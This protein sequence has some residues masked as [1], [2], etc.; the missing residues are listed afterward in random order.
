MLTKKFFIGLFSLVLFLG[1]TVFAATGNTTLSAADLYKK[2]VP[3]VL[4]LQTQD[5]TGSGV[6]LKEDGTFV[7]CF[8]VIANA[9]YIFAKFEDGSIY[10][11][12]GYRYLDPQND[13]AILTLDSTRKFIPFV[14]NPSGNL[15]I[16]EKAYAISNPQGIQFVLS[17]GLINQFNKKHI[18]FSAPVSPG[19]SGGAL[20]NSEGKLLGIINSLI[21]PSVAQNINFA[22]P[23]TYYADKINAPKVVN[24]EEYI[25]N[26]FM[27]SQV[28][29]IDEFDKFS[30][31]AAKQRNPE[32]FYKYMNTYIKKKG[33][34]DK[35]YNTMGLSA[36]LAYVE[37]GKLSYAD[38]AIKWYN[39]SYKDN[40]SVEESIVALIYLK[41][42]KREYGDL[43]DLFAQL[44]KKYK[45]TYVKFNQILE[46]TNKC[47]SDDEECF[48]YQGARY[49][50]LLIKIHD[51]YI[52][53]TKE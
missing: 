46:D 15:K 10:Y 9:D 3:S 12:N 35:F 16:G 22:I 52:K 11:V 26:E 42:L 17:D 39:L 32:M 29:N 41:S 8:H 20:F 5:G 2:K 14:L 19:S 28:D 21:D 25:W 33:I 31:F 1:Q 47:H 4:F 6:I 34:P 50:S 40:T 53:S 38:D 23:N 45:K 43:A 7:T 30:S 36:T 24:T 13:V 48:T 37:T 49:L 51:N 18:Q 27:I 44:E